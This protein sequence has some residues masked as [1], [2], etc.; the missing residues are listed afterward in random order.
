M[1]G[2]V[3]KGFIRL[4][5]RIVNAINHAKRVSLISYNQQCITQLALINIHP[6]EYTKGLP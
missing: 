2:F 6:N 5:T 3:K 4:L 1:F